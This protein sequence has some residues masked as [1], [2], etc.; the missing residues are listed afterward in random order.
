MFGES[1]EGYV[2]SAAM[3]VAWYA[4][5]SLSADQKPRKQTRLERGRWFTP[6]SQSHRDYPDQ[7]SYYLIAAQIDD[8]LALLKLMFMLCSGRK[9]VFPP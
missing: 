1:T 9:A 4:M 6:R 3:K 8:C 2:S 7:G 5:L